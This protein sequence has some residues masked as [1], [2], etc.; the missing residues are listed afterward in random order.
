MIDKHDL[1]NV[2]EQIFSY[3]VLKLLLSS[4]LIAFNWL[5]DDKTTGLIVVYCL[6]YLDTFTGLI[7][8]WKA[9]QV[10]SQ[11]FFR[12]STKFMVY[13]VMIVTGRLVDKVMPIAFA[14]SIVETFLSATE[15]ISIMENLGKM[16]APIPNKLLNILKSM[17]KEDK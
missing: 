4:T 16:G 14:A 10:S 13:F 17:Q 7:C 6:V 5:F 1:N 2:V 3:S 12:F 9:K 15:A 8:A 11:G